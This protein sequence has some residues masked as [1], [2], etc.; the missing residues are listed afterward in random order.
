MA[1]PSDSSLAFFSKATPNQWRFVYELRP[2]AIKVK[3]D[4]RSSKKGGPEEFI[5]LDTWFCEKLPQSIHG[6]KDPHVLYDELVQIAKWRLMMGKYRPKMLDLVRINTE[7]SV[8]NITRKAFKKLQQQKN[9]QQAITQL[10]NLKGI[11]PSTASAVLAAAFPE[12]APFMSDEGML[13]TPGVEA[14]DSTIAEYNNYSEQLRN[15]TDSLRKSDPDYKWTPHKVDQVLWIYY[16][17]KDFKPTLLDKMPRGDISNQLSDAADDNANVTAPITV[18]STTSIIRNNL[19][20]DLEE[21]SSSQSQDVNVVCN[22]SVG[23]KTLNGN[24]IHQEEDSESASVPYSEEDLSQGA[25]SCSVDSTAATI[26]SDVSGPIGNGAQVNGAR[27]SMMMSM[28]LNNTPNG[29]NNSL[30]NTTTASNANTVSGEDSNLSSVEEDDSLNSSSNQQQQNQVVA[31]STTS[32][33]SNL[34]L[35]PASEENSVDHSIG[36]VEDDEVSLDEAPP[37]KKQKT[38]QLDGRLVSTA[39]AAPEPT[40]AEA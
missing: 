9:P 25:A 27:T 24:F 39:L 37:I 35:T 18:S 23:S 34:V 6:R 40:G 31:S 13:S 12:E 16:L 22:D 1:D 4:Q 21:E 14:T 17:I 3:A 20:D 19:D 26:G 29:K 33:S 2:D 8:V 10:V 30:T 7:T 32:S 36:D 38:T 28:I 15:K 11:G 5:K